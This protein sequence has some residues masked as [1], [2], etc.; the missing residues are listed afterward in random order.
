M[1][2]ECLRSKK[3]NIPKLGKPTEQKKLIQ[4][5]VDMVQPLWK[6]V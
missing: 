1:Q 3:L 2:F 4:T 5:L 6:I